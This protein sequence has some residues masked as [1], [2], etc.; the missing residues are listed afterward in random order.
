MA[1][2]ATLSYYPVK[3]CAGT[4]VDDATLTPAGLAHDRSFMVTGADGVFRSQRRHPQLALI[5]PEISSDGGHLTL[6]GLGLD[7]LTIDVDTLGARRDVELFGVPY[8]G[9]DQGDEAAGWLSEFLGA[10]TRLMRV[11]PE[12]NRVTDGRTPGTSGYAD[13]CAVHVLSRSTLDLL[14]ERLAER[15][16]APLPMDRFRP[17]IVIEG[18]NEP[19]IEDR[20]RHITMGEAELGYTKPAIRCVVTVV[21]QGVGAKAGP[22]PLRTLA[23]YRRAA[24]GGVAFGT[25][26]AVLRPGELSV[27][28]QVIVGSWGEPEL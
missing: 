6:R 18:W 9:I 1:R 14:N 19:H 10:P 22:E 12:H 15:G 24:E 16:T 20:A 23:D 26:F 25:K 8:K 27:G 5:R 21:D 13:S 2:I 28:D 4:S 11:P 17:N 7:L 3:G